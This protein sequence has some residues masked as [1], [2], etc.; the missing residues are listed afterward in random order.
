[1]V[2]VGIIVLIVGAVFLYV[3]IPGLPNECG[4]V[5]GRPNDIE[6]PLKSIPERYKLY[7]FTEQRQGAP[8]CANPS[9]VIPVLFLHGSNGSYKQVHSLGLVALEASA[10]TVVYSLDFN[11]EK[12]LFNAAS[13]YDQV[14]TTSIAIDAIRSL[15]NNAPVVL[16]GHSMGGFVALLTAFGTDH[17]RSTGRKR[18][19]GVI[20]LNS[21]VV[22]PPVTHDPQL[23]GLYRD[24]HDGISKAALENPKHNVPIVSLT[25]GQRDNQVPSQSCDL[26]A[27][28]MQMDSDKKMFGMTVHTASIPGIWM[29]SDH[30]CITLCRE[31]MLLLADLIDILGGNHDLKETNNLIRNR[32][33]SCLPDMFL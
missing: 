12:I 20:T 3:T 26:S 4:E 30:N 1:V 29:E 25:G 23:N 27:V 8:V 9:S 24:L 7:Q 31:V 18:I 28:G 5:Y 15:H 11:E 10:C 32:L 21:P 17:A 19:A 22:V 33:V 14:N 2:S 16:I 6:V 13:I